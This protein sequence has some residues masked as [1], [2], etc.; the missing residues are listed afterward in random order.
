[1]TDVK[2]RI[3]E[4]TQ[5]LNEHNYHYYIEDNPVISDYEFDM[6]MKELE[7]LEKLHPELKLPES[8]TSRVGGDVT[9]TFQQVNH[10]VPM[11]SLPNT[12]SVEEITDFEQH[13]SK[14]TD[15]PFEYVCELKYDGLAISLYYNH[16]ILT[17]AVTRGNGIVGDDVTKNVKTIKTVPLKLM[18]DYPDFVCVRGEVIMPHKSF[19]MLNKEREDLGYQL[20]ANPRNAAS[21]TLK[22][23]NS[24]IVARRNLDFKPYFVIGNTGIDNHYDNL[25]KAKTWGFKIANDAALQRCKNIDEILHFINHWNDER[26]NLG[27]DIDGIVIKVNSY[28]LQQLLGSTAK[29][30]KWAIAYK[31]K[32]DSVSTEL[33]SVTYQVGRTG[34]ITPVANLTPVQLAGTIVKRASLYNFDMIRELDLHQHDYVFIEKGGEIIPK[35][36]GVDYEHRQPDGEK[37]VFPSHCPECGTKL[38]NNEGEAGFYCP[39]DTNCPPQILGRIEHF[40]SKKAMNIDSLGT[41]TV[42]LFYSNDIIHNVADIYDL[43]YEDIYGLEKISVENGKERR[44]R[45]QE[46]SVQNILGA[47]EKSKQNPFHRVFFALGIRYIGEVSSKQITKHF[48]NIDEIMS[49]THEQLLECE[50]VGDIMANSVIKFFHNEQNMEIIRRLREKGL[51]FGSLREQDGVRKQVQTSP[52]DPLGLFATQSEGDVAQE[53]VVLYSTDNQI[54]KTKINLENQRIVI[55]GT[56]KHFSREDIKSVV[57]SLGGRIM[58]S[59][60]R[61]TDFVLAGEDMGPQKL[62]KTQQL[63]IRILSEDDV[64][65]I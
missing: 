1:M 65:D 2:A 5:K 55:S 22:M 34:I 45:L 24:A 20:F 33:Q 3:A 56:F 62:L 39:N 60:S 50:G 49:A 59:V 15:R 4:L 6:M 32:A 11:A 63:N 17:H 9:E 25:M 30:P 47:I 18:N 12:Y 37:I 61:K 26:K 41:E 27:F 29:F 21:G 40:V 13:V 14:I 35:I 23:Q 19:D 8:P 16:G 57:E 48:K 38:V 28:P 7:H 53:S 52:D 46:K 36:T 44:I 31:F 10:D 54:V 64:F 51:N 43:K 42:S 58:S